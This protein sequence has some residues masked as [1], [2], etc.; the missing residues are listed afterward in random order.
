MWSFMTIGSGCQAGAQRA[1]SRA[2][3]STRRFVAVDDCVAV[4][5]SLRTDDTARIAPGH[6]R[7]TM[8]AEGSWAPASARGNLWLSRTSSQDRSATHPS[9]RAPAGDTASAPL[10]GWTDIDVRKVGV[11]N[12]A[13]DTGQ[14]F[15]PDPTS[16]DP[17]YP[18]VIV[19]I[20][21]WQPNH[22][23]RQNVLLIG[24]FDNRRVD[25][26]DFLDGGGIA[27]WVRRFSSGGFSGHWS[28]FG[29]RPESSGYFCAVPYRT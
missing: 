14:F 11:L 12:Y 1:S 19:L 23:L 28:R 7:I 4:D 5:D 25:G 26:F 10:F 15:V 17:L 18:G 20:Q 16:R 21:N 3:T 2:D 6:Y 24:T 27:L 9:A 13:P 8:I 29:R 22:G